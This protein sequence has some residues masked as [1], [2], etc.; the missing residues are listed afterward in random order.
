MKR[1]QRAVF[2]LAATV[3]LP[4][5]ES[6]PMYYHVLEA[7]CLLP[8]WVEAQQRFLVCFFCKGPISCCN[9][10]HVT[11]HLCLVFRIGIFLIFVI[12]LFCS[13]L[14]HNSSDIIFYLKIYPYL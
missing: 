4:Q 6:P 2:P 11:K 12:S 3:L 9:S 13:L 1:K 10:S 14:G 7:G 8:K 5:H